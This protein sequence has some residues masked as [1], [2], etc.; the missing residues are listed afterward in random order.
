[1]SLAMAEPLP[2]MN[3]LAAIRQSLLSGF[4]VSTLVIISRWRVTRCG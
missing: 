3:R 4:M 1:M 2:N